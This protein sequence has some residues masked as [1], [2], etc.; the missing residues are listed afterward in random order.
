MRNILRDKTRDKLADALNACGIT[1]VMAERGRAE[2]KVENSWYQRSLGII[3]I[4]DGP[5][6]WINILKKD[7]SRNS[8]PRWW[9]V[10]GIPDDRPV[11]D[12][13]AIDIK[14]VRKKTIP[15]FGKVIDVTWKGHDAGTG[16]KDMFYYD[17]EVKNFAIHAGNLTVHS[18]NREFQGWTVQ[19]DRRFTP[20]CEDWTGVR[21]MAKH[22]LSSARVL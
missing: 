21:Q 20:S 5:V 9:V 11:P 6:R 15:L 19:I 16:L 3:D 12:H 18:Y 10:L 8:P 13:K 14:T 4:P 2:E 22:I 17:E 1:A 7:G